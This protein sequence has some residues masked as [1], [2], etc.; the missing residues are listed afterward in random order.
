MLKNKLNS[1]NK[2]NKHKYLVHSPKDIGYNLNK[3]VL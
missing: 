1:L 3:Q 2:K